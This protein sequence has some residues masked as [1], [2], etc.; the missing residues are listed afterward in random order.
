M[1]PSPTQR[2]P[3]IWAIE[4][5]GWFAWKRTFG[6]ALRAKREAAQERETAMA[7]GWLNQM[8]ELGRPQ[9]YRV[10]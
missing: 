2:D 9:L 5:A 7:C 10:G 8:L 4:S 1:A 3:H 6:G